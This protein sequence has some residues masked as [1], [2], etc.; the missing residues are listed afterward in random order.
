MQTIATLILAHLIADFIL[1][2]AILIK[3]K[4]KSWNGIFIHALIHFFTLLLLFSKNFSVLNILF[5]SLLIC[6]MHYVIDY[7]KILYEKNETHYYFSF[8]IDQ[9]AHITFLLIANQL[10]LST[11]KLSFY[12]SELFTIYLSLS[13][14]FTFFIEITLDQKQRLLKNNSG[15]I[16]QMK[17]EPMLI[18]FIVF[19]LIFFAYL[20]T[21]I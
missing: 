12:I 21:K 11:L 4:F 10:F 8:I 5:A 18:R 17:L 16:L 13:I 20:L 3:Q 2:P 15:K 6:F 9:F 14:F 1:Q 7:L 19:N